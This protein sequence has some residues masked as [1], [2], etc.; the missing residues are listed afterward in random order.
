MLLKAKT[1]NAT[2]SP[3]IYLSV[4][5][6][7]LKSTLRFDISRIAINKK[8]IL[9]QADRK[10]NESFWI[11]WIHFNLEFYSSGNRLFKTIAKR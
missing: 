2:K 8:K 9:K 11:D 7:L 5:V 4:G 3:V 1:L 6:K 10:M